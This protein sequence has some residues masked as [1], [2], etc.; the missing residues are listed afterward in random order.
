MCSGQ[1]N[2]LKKNI[3]AKT[4][5]AK[6]EKPTEA[7]KITFLIFDELQFG[8]KTSKENIA[9]I[10]YS[11][12][13]HQRGKVEV[14]IRVFPDKKTFEKEIKRNFNAQSP[15]FLSMTISVDEKDYSKGI[16]VNDALSIAKS[17]FQKTK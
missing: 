11:G 9:V 15:N 1:D 3:M 5:Q 6:T 10:D 8:G 4:K 16:D 7:K 14:F 17:K 12:I 13:N 2:L